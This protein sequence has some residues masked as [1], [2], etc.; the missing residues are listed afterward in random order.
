MCIYFTASTTNPPT[1]S[2]ESVNLSDSSAVN[3]EG[4]KV[5]SK[6]GVKRLLLVK[7]KYSVP[8]RSTLEGQKECDRYPQPEQE[9]I[10]GNKN[11]G[12]GESP[13]KWT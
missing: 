5:E 11:K 9:R 8:E 6:N 7:R 10:R 3:I 2:R 12:E 4:K 1:S 13:E